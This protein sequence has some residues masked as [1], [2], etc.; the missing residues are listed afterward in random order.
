M[1][2]ADML[3][4]RIDAPVRERLADI[5]HAQRRSVA[6]VVRDAIARE[7]DRYDRRRAKAAEADR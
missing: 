6:A 7:I 2:K 1:R 3:T 4:M 5:A